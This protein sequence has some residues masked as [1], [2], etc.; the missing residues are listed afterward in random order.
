MNHIFLPSLKKLRIQNYTLYPNGLNFEH[1]FINGVNL[2]MGGNGMG[3]TTMVNIIKYGIIGNYKKAFGYTGTYMGKKIEKR[4]SFPQNYFRNRHDN[5]I[6]TEGDASVILEFELNEDYFVVERCLDDIELR[7]VVVTRA[8]IEKELAG[9]I[10]SQRKYDELDSKEK[11][12]CLFYNYEKEITKSAGIPF[13]DIIFFVNVV[14]FFG[15]DHKTILWNDG[16]SGIDV[17]D[18]LFNKYFNEPS[19]DKERQET[20]REAKYQESLY[21]AKSEEIR[22]IHNVL[23]KINKGNSDFEGSIDEIIINL[24]EEIEKI[25]AKIEKKQELRESL[26]AEIKILN[27]KI[28][29][30]SQEEGLIEKEKKV[31]EN[32]LFE[33]KWMTLHKNYDLH[34]QNIKINGLCP[35]CN[36]ELAKEY[37]SDSVKNSNSC[38]VCN[39]DIIDESNQILDKK[40]KGLTNKLE[41]TYT[42]I[43]NAQK[44]ISDKEK[45]LY[46]LDEEFRE[47]VS[48]KRE[49]ESKLRGLEYDDSKNEDGKKKELKEFYDE[50]AKLEL[51]KK[52][53]LKKSKEENLRAT[54]ISKKIEKHI[55][56][57]TNKFSILF[58]GFAEKFLGVECSLTYDKLSGGDRKRFYPVIDGKIRQYEEELSESQRFFIDHSFRMSILSFF[59]TKPAF[60]IVETPDSSLDI[61]YEFNAAE[62]FIKFLEKPNALILTSNLNNSEFL[63]YLIEQSTNVS[64][65]NLLEIGKK[66]MIQSNSES[67]KKIYNKIKKYL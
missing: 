48:K 49:L 46:N 60:Y 32:K 12:K 15:E 18:E 65:I 17:Q 21:K 35:M 23:K 30:Y 31:A 56:E 52:K 6:E 43:N 61:S 5:T 11:E 24:K 7:K 53:Y 55:T 9:E 50:I 63:N 33:G 57:N 27:N 28:N 34:L 67:M 41:E 3:K 62:V 44:E 51:L 2:I 45:K 40:Y 29:E 39:Q 36:K 25:D 58:S 54:S 22:A 66:T 8:G 14:L 59:Y 4:Q 19:L 10:V 37:I 1:D 13:D 16:Y 26:D 47:L 38:F 20:I 42:K 64:V